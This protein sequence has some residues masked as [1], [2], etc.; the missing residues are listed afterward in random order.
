MMYVQPARKTP[1]TAVRNRYRALFGLF[2]VLLAGCATA[3]AAS[4]PVGL[5]LTSART[6]APAMGDSNA[7]AN[8]DANGAA[9]NDPNA[10]VKSNA[11]A[12]ALLELFTSEGCSSTPPAETALRRIADE[13]TAA[14]QPVYTLAF[15]VPYWDYL[16]WKDR[17]ARNANTDRQ[18]AYAH[19]LGH[20]NIYTPQIVLD[21]AGDLP[22]GDAG[23][24]RVAIAT[25]LARPRSAAVALTLQRRAADGSLTIGYQ[26][27]GAPTGAT[28]QLA[29]AER[30]IVTDVKAG[31]NAGHS[32][33]HGPVIRFLTAQDPGNGTAKLVAP[34]DLRW[35]R[36]AII[37]FVQDPNTMAI[38]GATRLEL[39][40]LTTRP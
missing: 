5:G 6:T 10:P 20:A 37:G 31:E 4:E 17:Y 29:I 1:I 14:G 19:A 3:S 9:K 24:T 26:V 23:A 33:A 7:L 25:S 21:G 34:A 39:T 22:W 16:G 36:A 35:D 27:T 13:A 15:H 18:W 11:N 30:G 40:S 2:A 12:F 28:L 32:L 8:S 38:A